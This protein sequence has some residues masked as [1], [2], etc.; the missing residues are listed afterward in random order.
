MS[1]ADKA[2]EV[3]DSLIKQD[4]FYCQDSGVVIN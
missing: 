1:P 4:F 2:V 3:I